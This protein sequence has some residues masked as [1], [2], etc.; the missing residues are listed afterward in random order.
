MLCGPRWG[1]QTRG[2]GLGQAKGEKGEGPQEPLLAT[3]LTPLI[4]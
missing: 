4:P 1:Q 3:T 2:S